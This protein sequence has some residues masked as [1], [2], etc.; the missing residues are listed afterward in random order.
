ML[1]KTKRRDRLCWNKLTVHSPSLEISED[2]LDEWVIKSELDILHPV[3][4]V[5]FSLALCD[6]Y[7]VMQMS[8][9]ST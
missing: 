6:F 3:S 8:E 4:E 5:S 7:L 2:T 9:I 1:R